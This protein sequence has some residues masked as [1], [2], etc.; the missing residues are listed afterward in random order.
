MDDLALAGRGQSANTDYCTVKAEHDLSYYE[1][2]KG[3]Y[4]KDQME[5]THINI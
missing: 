5:S 3:E 1:I 4:N 2:L